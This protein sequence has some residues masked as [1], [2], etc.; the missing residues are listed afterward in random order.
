[1]TPYV[2]RDTYIPIHV[3]RFPEAS[4]R[5]PENLIP[6]LAHR[7]SYPS[8]CILHP[9]SCIWAGG[10]WVLPH[11]GFV[12]PHSFPATT[13]WQAGGLATGDRCLDRATGAGR[14]G[15]ELCLITGEGGTCILHPGSCIWAGGGQVRL[16]S[17]G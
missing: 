8:R 7:S 9:A 16:R 15:T 3:T 13:P 14:L 12:S 10:G 6:G 4:R 5:S 1:M 2:V 11:P 17:R